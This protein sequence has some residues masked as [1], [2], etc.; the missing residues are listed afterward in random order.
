MRAQRLFETRTSPKGGKQWENHNFQSNHFHH[1][2]SDQTDSGGWK[3]ARPGGEARS[4]S[5][6]HR[7][8]V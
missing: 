4:R 7:A 3:Q 6:A 5:P 1:G 2:L 8:N